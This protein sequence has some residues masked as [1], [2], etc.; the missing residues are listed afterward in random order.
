MYVFTNELYNFDEMWKTY[1]YD[2]NKEVVSLN[3]ELTLNDLW[4]A[5]HTLVSL[6]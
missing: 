2:A 5:N 6:S 1:E 3:T 4:I